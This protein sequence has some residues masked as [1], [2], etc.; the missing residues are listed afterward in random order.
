MRQLFSAKEQEMV[1]AVTRV[2]ELTRQIEM[3]R[4]H[5]SSPSTNNIHNIGAQNHHNELDKLRRELLVRRSN[6]WLL[7][8][9]IIV[10]LLPNLG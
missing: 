4:N 9:A 1:A 8:E 6:S 2:E 5:A 3:I 10:S 7:L